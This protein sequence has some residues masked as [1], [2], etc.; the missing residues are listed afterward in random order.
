MI[1]M[2]RKFLQKWLKDAY[3]MEKSEIVMLEKQAGRLKGYPFVQAKI[4]E[5]LEQTRWQTEQIEECLRKVGTNPSIVKSALGKAV[6]NISALTR[7]MAE[8]EVLKDIIAD[9]A[10]ENME[11]T[12]YLSIMEAAEECGE[13]D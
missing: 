1:P 2:N 3:A 4:N 8:D 10:F 7:V 13:T 11:I 5:H 12:S 9:S 6:G